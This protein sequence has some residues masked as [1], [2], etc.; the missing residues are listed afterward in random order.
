MSH[1]AAVVETACGNCGAALGGAFCQA[2]GQKAAGPDVEPPRSLPRGRRRVR[3]RR[4]KDRPDAAAAADE[5]GV[6]DE[7]VPQRPARALRLA[8]P[9]VP[10]LQPAVF[11][12]GCSSPRTPGSALSRLPTEPS[13]GDAPMDAGDGA[14][15]S[16]GSL[17]AGRPR[18]RP[19]FPARDVRA[20]AGVRSAHVGCSIAGRGRST[21]RTCTI[22]FT[23]TRSCFS[24]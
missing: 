20:D 7:G 23:S 19:R 13:P 3:P 8:A 4:R 11:R 15:V 14:T 5:T 2:C 22:R 1:D 12:P 9:P 17:V 16:R 18:H 24:C 6:A 10:R 21:R